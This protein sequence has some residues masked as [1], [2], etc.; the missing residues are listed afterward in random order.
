MLLLLLVLYLKKD[1]RLALLVEFQI[2]GFD[3]WCEVAALCFGAL[4]WIDWFFV[5]QVCDSSGF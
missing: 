3:S 1:K 2:G 4:L 5:V